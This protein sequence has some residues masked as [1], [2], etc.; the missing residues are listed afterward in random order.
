MRFSTM[1]WPQTG[2]GPRLARGMRTSLSLASSSTTVPR[3]N[4]AMSFM[5]RS[6][7]SS[8]CSIRA[9]P[10]LPVAGHPRRRQRVSVEQPDHVQALLGADERAP[11]ALDVADVDQPLDDRRARGGRADPRVL[12]RLAQL[13]VVDELAGRLHRREQRRVG[14]APRRLGLLLLRGDLERPRRL[15]LVE[16]RQRLVGALVV[17]GARPVLEALAVDAAPARHDQHPAARA[18]HVRRDRRLQ[19][20]VLEHRVGMEDREEA[21]RRPCRRRAC[22][23]RTS[24]RR[25][26]R[27]SSG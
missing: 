25:R 22:R 27:P 12:H 4:S 6:R 13:V 16:L 10:V 24:G 20:R 23:R 19:P 9:E 18:E 26:A 21:A 17:V 3:A 2:Q 1:S 8:P 14:V 5:N 7:V 15:A 11:V